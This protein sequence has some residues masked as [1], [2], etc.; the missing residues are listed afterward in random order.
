MSE[1]LPRIELA[2]LHDLANTSRS[3]VLAA[4]PNLLETLH[5]PTVHDRPPC[6]IVPA[7]VDEVLAL[8]TEHLRPTAE[9]IRHS[10]CGPGCAQELLRSH[11]SPRIRTGAR[12][13]IIATC[14]GR[15]RLAN[16]V[17]PRVGGRSS[18]CRIRATSTGHIAAGARAAAGTFD[19]ILCARTVSDDLRSFLALLAFQQP[20]H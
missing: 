1:L 19:F 9:A 3:S 13:R 2:R 10:L 12:E 6:P 4:A 14:C 8:G 5:V 16:D 7:R 11:G 15:A 20:L 18:I 17:W